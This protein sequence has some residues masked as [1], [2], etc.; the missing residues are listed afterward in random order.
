[1]AISQ[2]C[3]GFLS[4]RTD[5]LPNEPVSFAVLDVKSSGYDRSKQ[6]SADS[7]LGTVNTD[8]SVAER[9]VGLLSATHPVNNNAERMAAFDTAKKVRLI[10]ME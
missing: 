1:L 5:Q 10:F 4:T 6:G 9:N 7:V 3:L 2:H 8:A